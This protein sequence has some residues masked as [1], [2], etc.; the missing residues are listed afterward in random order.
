MVHSPQ[1]PILYH[2]LIVHVIELV[3]MYNPGGD[4]KGR[5]YNILQRMGEL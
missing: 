5:P 1:H 3:D 4:H 2:I